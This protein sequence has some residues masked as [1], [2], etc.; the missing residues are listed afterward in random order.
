MKKA[1]EA[2]GP[3]VEN[4][5]MYLGKWEHVLTFAI[6]GGKM[7]NVVAF[8]D[9][10]GAPWIH[11]QWV[12]PSSRE[13]LLKDFVGCGE[14]ASKILEVSTLVFVFT[15]LSPSL[16]L[17]CFL[18]LTD[19]SSSLSTDPKNGHYSTTF[20]HPRTP[21][22]TSAYLEMQHTPLLPI[23]VS[24]RRSLTPSRFRHGIIR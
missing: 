4:R 18:L 20:Q 11:R 21:K 10:E 24:K 19:Y 13:A 14:T 1:I 23:S 15:S 8:K 7:L 17:S 22:E 3:D 9:G 6:R 12:V 16:F 5:Q 2:V